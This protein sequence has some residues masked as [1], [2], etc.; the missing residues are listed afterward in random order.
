MS[1]SVHPQKKLYLFRLMLKMN[2][3]LT[4]MLWELPKALLSLAMLLGSY[5]Y[6]AQK[7][8]RSI[9]SPYIFTN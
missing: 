4:C 8:W 1:T 7:V 9:G 2:M 6:W 3:M 5:V